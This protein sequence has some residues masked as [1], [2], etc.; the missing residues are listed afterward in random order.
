[1]RAQL[2]IRAEEGAFVVDITPGSGADR[3]GL[4]QGDVI[5]AVDGEEITSNE[6]LG[7]IV[8]SHEPGDEVEIR[9]EREGRERTVRA[10]IGRQGG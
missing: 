2:G 7:K 3:A 6:R 8:R 1:V 4:R 10:T 9:I 5:L